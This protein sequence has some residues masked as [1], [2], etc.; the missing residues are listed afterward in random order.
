MK[1]KNTDL[2]IDTKQVKHQRVEETTPSPDFWPPSP[3]E[4][5]VN[6]PVNYWPPTPT[7]ETEDLNNVVFNIDEDKQELPKSDVVVLITQPPPETISNYVRPNDRRFRLQ[8]NNMLPSFTNSEGR[9]FKIGDRI[10]CYRDGLLTAARIMD[11]DEPSIPNVDPALQDRIF[12]HFEG[13][14]PEQAKMVTPLDILPYFQSGPV[15]IG[16]LGKDDLKSWQEYKCFYQSEEGRLAREHTA[17]VFDETMLLHEC[18]CRYRDNKVTSHPE[19]PDRCIEIM[20]TFEIKRIRSRMATKEELESCHTGEHVVTYFSYKRIRMPKIEENCDVKVNDESVADIVDVEKKGSVD[21]VQKLTEWCPPALKDVMSCGELGICCDTTYNSAG[22]PIAARMAAG[23]VIE[24]VGAVASGKIANGFAIVRP[25]G[26]HAERNQAMGFCYFNNVGIAAN[27]ILKNYP[28]QIKKILIVDWDI[29]HGNGTQDMFYDRDDVLY[30]SLHRWDN[31]NFYPYS[32]SPSDLGSGDGLGKNVNITFSSEEDRFD[33]MGDTEY[34]AA[35]KHIVMPIAM[36]YNPDL[37]IVSAGFD[38]A[39]GH[40]GFI[41]GY[42]ITPRGGYALEPLSASA[43]ACLSA[44]LGPELSP[45][46][47]Y[48]LIGGLNSVKPNSAAVSSFQKVVATLKPYWKFSE[49]VMRD[50]FRFSL[51]SEWRAINSLSTRP[52]RAPKPKRRMPVEG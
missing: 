24:I 43:S 8:E 49:E 38:A 1:R 5:G 34:V 45:L 27:I 17:I 12:V 2:S 14:G 37:V 26:H 6:D 51:P 9:A 25:P 10:A 3:I 33:A 35:F 28:N 23:S 31:G 22:T 52:K 21:K 29:H 4:Y 30:L 47:Q 16:P 39:E 15:I 44:L 32:G 40:D 18:P 11:I 50:D 46:E 41:G 19:N 7:T 36:Q 48:Q 20:G 42:K 13:W